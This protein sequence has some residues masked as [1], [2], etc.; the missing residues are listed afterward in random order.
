MQQE[1]CIRRQHKGCCWIFVRY[2]Y[3]FI[4]NLEFYKILI[5]SRSYGSYSDKE[6]TRQQISRGLRDL[7]SMNFWK[8]DNT[9]LEILTEAAQKSNENFG[10]I[11]DKLGQSC[12]EM[13]MRCRLEGLE[14]NCTELFTRTVTPDGHCCFFNLHLQSR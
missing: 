2:K 5:I 12:G 13:L 9:S 10:S 3:D 11:M 4:W 14:R 8:V 7:S 1:F 6:S